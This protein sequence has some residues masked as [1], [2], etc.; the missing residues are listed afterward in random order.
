MG[1]LIG[2]DLAIR[3]VQ[4]ADGV[5]LFDTED[6]LSGHGV[7]CAQ[8]RRVFALVKRPVLKAVPNIHRLKPQQ[9]VNF[10]LLQSPFQIGRIAALDLEN[11]LREC[12]GQLEQCGTDGSSEIPSRS[13]SFRLML[14]LDR[15][16]WANRLA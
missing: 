2:R 15:I 1:A 10:V 16:A 11:E 12:L 9:D 14:F 5:Q 6:G 3:P 4:R 7:T 8:H 13:A